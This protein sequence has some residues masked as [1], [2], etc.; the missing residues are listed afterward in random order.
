MSSESNPYETPLHSG[1]APEEP[2]PF[3]KRRAVIIYL[4]LLSLHLSAYYGIIP[5]FRDIFVKLEVDLP[6]VTVC[7]LST[8]YVLAGAAALTVPFA[9]SLS[10]KRDMA[11]WY[12][13]VIVVMVLLMIYGLFRPLIGIVERLNA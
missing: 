4:L 6:L 9:I 1:R 5:Q 8:W 13:P 11:V 10:L 12:A 7:L 3:R 2:R